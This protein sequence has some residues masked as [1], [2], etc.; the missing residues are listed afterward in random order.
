MSY[1]PDDVVQDGPI[2]T[3]RRVHHAIKLLVHASV[4]G[5]LVAL[6][7]AF[8][9]GLTHVVMAGVL[10]GP[11][12]LMLIKAF[13]P[14]N[15]WV[16]AIPRGTFA[17]TI[18]HLCDLL[19]D[20]SCSTVA[21]AVTYLAARRFEAAGITLALTVLAYFACRSKAKP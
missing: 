13:W 1:S 5:L 2:L 21:L 12:L 15:A 3:S 14:P 11:V 7:A 17:W 20:G 10:G 4:T 16:V 6:F 8:W 9:G 19:T 18:D